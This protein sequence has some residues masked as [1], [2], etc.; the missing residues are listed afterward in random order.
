MSSGARLHVC[1]LLRWAA[2]CSGSARPSS[3]RA[4]GRGQF[5]CARSLCSRP[6][7][8]SAHVQSRDAQH[9]G[10]G[11]GL[12]ASA[13]DEVVC[14][15]P[16]CERLPHGEVPYT[17][18]QAWVASARDAVHVL[19]P[20]ALQTG[21]SAEASASGADLL[22][23]L[24]WLLCDAVCAWREGPHGEWR[25]GADVWR[26]LRRSG[27]G[28]S[29]QAQVQLRCSLEHLAAAWHS[30]LHDRVPFQYL[31]A[32]QHWHDI[33]LAVGPGILNPRPETEALVQLAAGALAA[34]PRLGTGHWADVGTGS[35]ALAVSVARLLQQQAPPV[36]AMDISPVA[37]A[38]ATFNARRLGV[39]HRVETHL[40]CWLQPLLAL[41]GPS[42]LDGIVSN[43]PYVPRQRI[44]T[45]QPEVALHEPHL[46]LDGG[47]GDGS[48]ALVDLIGE[49][50]TALRPGGFVALETDGRPQAEA[51]A[52]HLGDT[53]AF[54]RVAVTQDCFGVHRFVSA[55]RRAPQ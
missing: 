42:C 9:R 52:R 1:H 11:W 26:S 55:W 47:P 28:E 20:Q 15:V 3:R 35:G 34:S 19:G 7:T 33:T 36:A 16:L 6:C 30:R 53:G 14:A 4:G 2:R 43:P 21:G 31:V 41:R 45:L 48:D 51:V 18:L 25:T 5:G 10:G 22:L 23:E 46:A 8:Y 32:C 29:S 44:A 38:Y 17:Q 49:L 40:G 54:E 39:G 37:L 13:A 12:T 27:G 50:A 24:D